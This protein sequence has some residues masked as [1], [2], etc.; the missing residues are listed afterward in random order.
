MWKHLSVVHTL[1]R[2]SPTWAHLYVVHALDGHC[3][4]HVGGALG[5]RDAAIHCAHELLDGLLALEVAAQGRQCRP[6]HAHIYI[7]GPPGKGNTDRANTSGYFDLIKIKS[8]L[9][10]Q[11]SSTSRLPE[12]HNLEAYSAPPLKFFWQ[13]SS[14]ALPKARPKILT[15][16]LKP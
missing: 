7:P 13:Y 15:L 16:N 3:E 4:G 5:R 8:L 9:Q 14:P 1:N 11:A 6:L 10:G 2:R 12:Q